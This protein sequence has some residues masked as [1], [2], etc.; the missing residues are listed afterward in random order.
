MAR[1]ELGALQERE[2][3]L[4]FVATTI[5]RLG[6]AMA[7]I[8]LA[9]GVLN[10]TG[11]VSDLG[12]VLAAG[13]VP[14]VAFVLIGGVWADRIP[15]LRVMAVS[16]TVA[17][18]SQ[19][20]TGLLFLAGGARVWELM[21]LAALQGTARAFGGPAMGALIPDT[22]SPGRLQQA[23]ALL[24]M[25]S[26][27]VDIGGAAVGGLFVAAIGPGWTMLFNAATSLAEVAI[28]FLMRVDE[29]ADVARERRAFRHDFSEGW[30]AVTSRKWLWVMFVA[31]AGFVLAVVAPWDVLGPALAR[32]SLGGPR[33]WG[34]IEAG[35]G[36]GALAGGAVVLRLRVS[37]PLL[38]ATALNVLYIPALATFALAS[39]VVL[40]VAAA[41]VGGAANDAYLVLFDTTIQRLVPRDV[42]ARVIS[43]DWFSDAATKPLGLAVVGPIAA[44]VGMSTVFWAAAIGALVVTALTVVVRDVRTL[45]AGA[46]PAG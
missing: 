45:R 33:A 23:T 44:R 35:Y 18:V 41:V 22:I 12:F 43:F 6:G 40:I 27:S 31:A 36:L 14:F 38:T 16:G 3:R 1:P 8:A 34:F 4:L 17:T 10:L 42:L 32:N 37:R 19:T 29:S 13:A 5:T 21:V 46:L 30:R 11:S 25:S 24:Y 20:A 9:F 28:R 7:P 2:F 26:S 39:P 15:R